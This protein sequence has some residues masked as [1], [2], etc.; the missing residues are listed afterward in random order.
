MAQA[1][2]GLNGALTPCGYAPEMWLS[3]HLGDRTKAAR[4]C[5]PCPVLRHCRDL[6]AELQPQYG[7]YAGKDYTTTPGRPK[8]AAS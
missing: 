8:K 5:Q 1:L 6:A 4:M 3:D 2:A 7:V